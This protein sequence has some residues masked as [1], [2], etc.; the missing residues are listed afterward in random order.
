MLKSTYIHFC[1][2]A[3][4]I[5]IGTGLRAW[6]L[7][8]PLLWV[9][10]AESCINALTILQ[11]GYPTD[12]YQNLPIYEN[13]LFREWPEH[14]EYEFK[15]V[16]YS[17]NGLAIYHGWLPLYSIAGALAL[18]GIQPD[19]LNPKLEVLHSNN[20]FSKR[21][22]IPR[23]PSI[24]CTFLFLLVL[25]FLAK[26]LANTG[27]ANAALIAAVF[28]PLMIYL[29]RQA[30]YYSYALLL[31][32][33]CALTIWNLTKQ[34]RWIDYILC[35]IAFVLLFY[36]HIM[37][38]FVMGL[39]LLFMFPFTLAHAKSLLK[40]SCMSVLVLVFTVPWLVA[41]DFLHETSSIPKAWPLLE[42][43]FDLWPI[44]N[45]LVF[46]VICAIGII[47]DAVSMFYRKNWSNRFTYPFVKLRLSYYFLT[48]W[49]VMAF[50]CFIYLIPAA[51][52]WIE[53]LK[54]MVCIPG[55]LLLSISLEAFSESVLKKKNL[56][57]AMLLMI[58][59]LVGTGRM[60]FYKE[61]DY[62]DTYRDIYREIT[63]I[64]REQNIPSNTKIYAQQN[65]QLPITY[66][67]G[68][69]VQG[70][71]PVRKSFLDQ[72]PGNI[73]IIQHQIY[74][75]ID[76]NQ[77]DEKIKMINKKNDTKHESID[78]DRL[79]KMTTWDTVNDWV[80]NTYPQMNPINPVEEKMIEYSKEYTK[81]SIRSFDEW[82]YMRIEEKY[83]P[84]TY[85]DM[86]RLFFYRF[87]DF[88]NRL[89]SKVNFMDRIS[90][91]CAYIIPKNWIIFDTDCVLGWK[92]EFEG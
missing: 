19:P 37:S 88:Q 44:S 16:S 23:I 82:P 1:I 83:M 85:D 56:W 74:A 40:F 47:I 29:G 50:F 57:L 61:L 34:G 69:P 76:Q 43:P 46:I 72:Y 4:L 64:F 18:G 9:D 27:A 20:E 39:V 90:S 63:N 53:R 32:C 49:L 7:D 78:A 52:Y 42:F 62:E 68:I 51:S 84:N 35:G 41:T 28:P 71:D 60:D 13:T 26:S 81:I 12:T 54:M 70:I 67:S 31:S 77:I 11:T 66:Y 79:H 38:C 25:F 22:L 8:K 30:R 91:G 2:A 92:E 87:T 6:N 89:G 75:H 55:I 33:L 58:A 36:T 5:L 86:T 15:D 21:T 59:L 3:L 48:V 10:E 80:Q 14:P 24:L 45:Y 73:I 17:S 65:H